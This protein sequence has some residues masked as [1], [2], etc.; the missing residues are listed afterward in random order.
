[1][2]KIKQGQ[3]FVCKDEA[4]KIKIFTRLENEGYPIYEGSFKDGKLGRHS[5]NGALAIVFSGNEFQ[6][7]PREFVKDPLNQEEFFSEVLI[8]SQ[9]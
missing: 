3:G 7:S 8:A 4:E 1:M 5:F 2:K 6:G 9:G